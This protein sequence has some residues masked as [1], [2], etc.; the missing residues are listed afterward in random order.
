M[1]IG[2]PVRA[3]IWLLAL[4]G[5]VSAARAQVAYYSLTRYCW[6]TQ[7]KEVLVPAFYQFSATASGLNLGW[8]TL[9]SPDMTVS[10]AGSSVLASFSTN[11]LIVDTNLTG[12]LTNLNADFPVGSYKLTAQTISTNL[13]TGKVTSRTNSYA[14][15]L[16]NDF[17]DPAPALLSPQPPMWLAATQKFNWSGYAAP[18]GSST[19]FY[20]LEGSFDATFIQEILDDGLSALTNFNWKAVQPNLSPTNTSITVSNLDVTLDHIVW[21]EFDVASPQAGVPIGSVTSSTI[22]L[23]LY[24]GI[25]TADNPVLS[26]SMLPDGHSLQI[27]VQGHPGYPYSIQ[28]T[29]TLVSNTWEVLGGVLLGTNGV[30][31]FV[32]ETSNKLVHFYRAAGLK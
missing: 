16:T 31:T 2:K 10:L 23:A 1:I 17:A 15:N 8:V 18:N 29:S 27:T 4:W 3:A 25:G 28:A 24:P 12:G 13:F 26:S 9:E 20:L 22:N 30:A 32:D 21:L 5:F 19:S 6:A 14:I 11:Y 7:A